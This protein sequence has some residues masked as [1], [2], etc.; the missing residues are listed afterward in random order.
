MKQPKRLKGQM[1]KVKTT[2]RRL[3]IFQ[4]VGFTYPYYFLTI[5]KLLLISIVFIAKLWFMYAMLIYGLVLLLLMVLNTGYF[6][7]KLEKKIAEK[8]P[9][10]NETNLEID[11]KPSLRLKNLV[12]IW[13][14]NFV[15]YFILFS[16]RIK[17][18]TFEEL[19]SL[20]F[21]SLLF[22]LGIGV[23]EYICSIHC[24]PD[25]IV[26]PVET[27]EFVHE[28]KRLIS[29]KNLYSEYKNLI[30]EINEKAL[31]YIPLN[32]SDEFELKLINLNSKL[33]TYNSKF[34]NIT[35]ESIF[36]TGLVLSGF[37]TIITTVELSVLKNTFDEIFKNSYDIFTNIIEK[38]NN[39]KVNFSFLNYTANEFFTII[40]LLTLTCST[41]YILVLIMRLRINHIYIKAN[42]AMAELVFL[43][44]RH[45][46]EFENKN[47]K[48]LEALYKK[49]NFTM[50]TTESLVNTLNTTNEFISLYRMFGII[51]F[52]LIIVISSFQ[53]NFYFGLAISIFT[54]VTHLIKKTEEIFK[55]EKIRNLIRKY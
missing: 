8:Y 40:S 29:K 39:L 2:T 23:V 48:N 54:I 6:K 45:K 41:F 38:N 20:I 18:F 53:I 26:E 9:E 49:R 16:T 33:S 4:C 19:A 50:M 30:D 46:D 32:E 47:E 51:T 25:I 17:S 15:L 43:S 28:R 31:G 22:S 10:I 35:L 24:K 55:L 1:T 27:Y 34:E 13:L 7:R 21:L 42:S 36:I 11:V 44:N 14:F 52:Y 5:F 12:V 3:I 37:F